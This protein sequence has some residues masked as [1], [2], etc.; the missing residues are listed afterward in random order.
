MSI[1]S[2]GTE[3]WRWGVI[4]GD[5]Q[6][7][8]GAS[9]SVISPSST[10]TS[11]GVSHLG[12]GNPT[13]HHP[14]TVRGD[15]TSQPLKPP[16]W[17]REAKGRCPLGVGSTKLILMAHRN[18]SCYQTQFRLARPAEEHG[19]ANPHPLPLLSCSHVPLT[20]P[21]LF[22]WSINCKQTA[23]DDDFQMY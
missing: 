16:C 10:P 19:G 5:P 12:S 23:L 7:P 22:T 8:P 11:P 21:S 15:L 20:S 1:S 18:N 17:S 3:V 9:I 4:L 14:L 2:R 13:P 6:V